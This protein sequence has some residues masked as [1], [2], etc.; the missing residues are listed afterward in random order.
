MGGCRGPSWKPGRSWVLWGQL[1]QG[2]R[3]WVL[4]CRNREAWRCGDTGHEVL[5]HYLVGKGPSGARRCA[6]CRS[7]TG[8]LEGGVGVPCCPSR[9]ERPDGWFCRHLGPVPRPVSS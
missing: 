1:P 4:T 9:C 7:H 2:G 8:A 5:G 6:A 3:V